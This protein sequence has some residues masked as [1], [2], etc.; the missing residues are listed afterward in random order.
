M[1]TGPGFPAPSHEPPP[2]RDFESA[3]ASVKAP[4]ITMIVVNAIAVLTAPV[5]L[6]LLGPI[7]D[8]I[9]KEAQRDRELRPIAEMY[10]SHA[11]EA[12]LA[13]G[14][15]TGVIAILGAVRMLQ[16]RSYGLALAAAVLT[17]VNLASCC[18]LINLGIG[19]WALV[20]LMRDD[21]QES[22]VRR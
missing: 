16:G 10:Q 13:V 1:T 20:V 4:A 8:E 14:L 18:C 17:M 7:R 22:F 9:A 12:V 11:F 5:M 3:R 21:V 15:V 19:I 2:I 6:L